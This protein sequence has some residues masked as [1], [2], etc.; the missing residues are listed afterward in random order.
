MY[1]S[2][3]CVMIIIIIIIVTMM[4]TRKTC[5]TRVANNIPSSE[6][7]LETKFTSRALAILTSCCWYH[8][9]DIDGH[10]HRRH[11]DHQTHHW[12]PS[13]EKVWKRMCLRIRCLRLSQFRRNVVNHYHDYPQHHHSYL[14]TIMYHH[15]HR[16]P[17]QNHCYL[18]TI[19]T[20]PG[21]WGCRVE[22]GL[23]GGFGHNVGRHDGGTSSDHR[24]W[25]SER[26]GNWCKMIMAKKNDVIMVVMIIAGI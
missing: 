23:E 18:V 21:C 9:N 11:H 1:G 13:L 8:E 25:W 22:C 7:H 15:R 26:W 19:I 2:D 14:V 17:R 12:W 3:L 20:C 5:L 24:P 16:Y 4:F 10:H 6:F